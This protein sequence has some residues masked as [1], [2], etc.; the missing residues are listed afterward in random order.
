MS[1]NLIVTKR[2]NELI[3]ACISY[4]LFRL[5]SGTG[6]EHLMQGIQEIYTGL[7]ENPYQY[8]ISKDLFLAQ[9][10]YREAYIRGMKY[11]VI[12]RIEEPNMVYVLGLFHDLENYTE[13]ID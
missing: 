2:A 10:K 9:K 7:E 1:Y 4:L 6:A 12:F 13:K 11:K 3:D 8:R 5:K